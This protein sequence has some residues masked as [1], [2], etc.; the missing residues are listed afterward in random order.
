MKIIFCQKKKKKKKIAI[1]FLP[2]KK[3]F[4]WHNNSKKTNKS[5]K[6]Q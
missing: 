3:S 6:L 1:L 5:F 2:G 4:T